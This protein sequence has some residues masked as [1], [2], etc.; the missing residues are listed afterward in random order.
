MATL[1]TNG[2][3]FNQKKKNIENVDCYSQQQES[4][5]INMNRYY[6]VIFPIVSFFESDSRTL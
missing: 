3:D 1:H 6:S 5:Y 2:I 4:W